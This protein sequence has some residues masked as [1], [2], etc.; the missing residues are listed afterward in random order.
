[1]THGRTVAGTVALA[2][3]ATVGAVQA[4]EAPAPLK[5]GVTLHPYYSWVM[6]V[7]A[8][9]PIEVRAVLPGDVDAGDYQ[10]RPEDIRKLTD[11]DAIVVNGLGHDDFIND[12]VKASGNRTIR[13][14][15]PND[16]VPLLKS[17]R[18]GTVNSHTFISFSNAI[19]QT[20]AIAKALAE[21]R[22]ALSATL[23]QNAAAYVRRL[24]AIKSKAAERLVDAR[25]NRVVTVHDGYSYLMQEFGLD[26]AGVVE[27]AH[28]LIPSA[29]ELTGMV[30]LLKREQVRVVFSE[31]TFPEPL[32]KIL[33]DEGQARVYLISHIASGAF[34]A[35]KFETE[36]QRNV[37]VM[38]QALVTDPK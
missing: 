9:T 15:R 38:V 7:A 6:N 3:L 30:D 27:P 18:G 5:V 11:L 29:K 25:I 13:V 20:Y 4:A 8:N 14:I 12:M 35:D 1:M 28:G 36:M 31:E 32:L 2:L 24:R 37:D 17:L 22:P 21:L 34:T 16:G 33:R 19:T 26:I 23:E 10:P